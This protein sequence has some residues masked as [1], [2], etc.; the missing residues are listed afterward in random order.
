VRNAIHA[1]NANGLACVPKQL[2]RPRSVEPTLDTANGERL[3]HSTAGDNS[4]LY[5]LA[6]ILIFLL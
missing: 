1:L 3:Q 6:S 4:V 2:P 5:V